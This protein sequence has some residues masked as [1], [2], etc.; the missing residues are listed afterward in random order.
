MRS[1]ALVSDM[2]LR[3]KSWKVKW[4]NGMPCFFACSVAM[5]LTRCMAVCSELISMGSPVRSLINR[6][7]WSARMG[8]GCFRSARIALRFCLSSSHIAR[9]LGCHSVM[10]VLLPLRRWIISPL[11]CSLAS[12]RSRTSHMRILQR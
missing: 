7:R 6:C 3:F 9:S 1:I 12:V 5:A 2:P 4:V 11:S 8:D 10:L